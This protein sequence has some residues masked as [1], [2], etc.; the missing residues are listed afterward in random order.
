MFLRVVY[1]DYVKVN[2]LVGECKI[3]PQRETLTIPNLELIAACLSVR[4]VQKGELHW[5]IHRIVYWIDAASVLD[6]IHNQ[7]KRFKL[8][9]AI[10]CTVQQNFGF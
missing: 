8:F 7:E 6:F 3:A 10:D 9:V 2:F 1:E 4:H 5:E